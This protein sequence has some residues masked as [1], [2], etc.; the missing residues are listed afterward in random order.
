[1]ILNPLLDWILKIEIDSNKW[2]SFLGVCSTPK[3][4]LDI[5]STFCDECVEGLDEVKEM[6]TDPTM[7]LA[8]KTMAEEF[9]TYAAMPVSMCNYGV[10]TFI[11]MVVDKLAK[12][13]STNTC[14]FFG[15]CSA[16]PMTS[17]TGDD[18]CADCIDGLD[19][20]KAAL[21]VVK[22]SMH[23]VSMEIC[24]QIPFPGCAMI[25]NKIFDYAFDKL[26]AMDSQST[27][28]LIG[29]CSAKP[30]T[31]VTDDTV[32]IVSKEWTNSKRSLPTPSSDNPCTWSP[33]RSATHFPSLDAS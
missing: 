26:A 17:V 5:T 15:V 21:P 32:R 2:C 4:A 11:D 29:V 13:D 9:C 30:I 8:L 31:I 14:S 12:I 18:W 1:M 22:E 20:F 24:T 6:M 28:S 3:F 33:L 27:C 16:N 25:F 10:D 7:R 23:L 19:D